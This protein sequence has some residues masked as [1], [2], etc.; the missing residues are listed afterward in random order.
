MTGIV[1]LVGGSEHTTG[2]EEIDRQ[3][4]RISGARRP[5]VA[6][7]LAASPDWR[8]SF[9]R[10]QAETWWTALGARARCAF[11]GEDDPVERAADLLAKADLVVITGGRPW[12]VRRHLLSTGLGSLVRDRWRDGVPVSG[13]SAGAMA[14]ASA[15]WSVR[16]SAPLGLCSG[17]GLIPATL[18]AP[19]AGRHGVDTWAAITQATHP[20][21]EVLGIPDRTA[22]MVDSDGNRDVLGGAHLVTYAGARALAGLKDARQPRA[23][24]R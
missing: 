1:A 9:K 10:A 12:L 24:A 17:L 16:P 14:L 3:L 20:E 19:H 8:R 23:V 5:E 18:V 7:L 13:S 22:L 15:A 6:V 2:C 4:L 11:A 21:L